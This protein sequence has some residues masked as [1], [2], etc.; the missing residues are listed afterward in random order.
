MFLADLKSKI[1]NLFST[2]STKIKN[3]ATVALCIVKISK[4]LTLEIHELRNEA[5]VV[6]TTSEMCIRDYD[7]QEIRTQNTHC[8]LNVVIIATV[9]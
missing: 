7:M 3:W 8:N 5:F 4:L 2:V 1:A 6:N 9:I